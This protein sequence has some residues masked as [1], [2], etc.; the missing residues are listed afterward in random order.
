M[1]SCLR[2]P[3]E[4]VVVEEGEEMSAGPS[5]TA[6]VDG[7]IRC[8]EHTGHHISRDM[9]RRGFIRCEC[10]CDLAGLL[11]EDAVGHELAY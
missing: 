6:A 3:V 10:V 9:K 5:T 7:G 4:E 8:L 1:V 11:N 2:T